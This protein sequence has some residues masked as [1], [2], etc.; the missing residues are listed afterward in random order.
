MSTT[1]ARK[2]EPIVPVSAR[3]GFFERARIAL[4]LLAAAMLASVLFTA[5]MPLSV[6]IDIAVAFVTI[7]AA[8]LGLLY[9]I[10]GY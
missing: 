7:L 2:S 9:L 4:A 3:T 1:R 6:I 5:F 10:W 8:I